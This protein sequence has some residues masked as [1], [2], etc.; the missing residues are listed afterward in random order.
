VKLKRGT[1]SVSRSST[2]A[3]QLSRRW[4]ILLSSPELD[5]NGQRRD[6]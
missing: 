6:R 5:L 1:R 4:M 2:L 3:I